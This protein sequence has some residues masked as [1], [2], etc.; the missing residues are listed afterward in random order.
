MGDFADPR[1]R[2]IDRLLE[3]VYEPGVGGVGGM[4]G[5]GLSNQRLLRWLGDLRHYFSADVRRIIVNDA[6]RIHG[7]TRFVEDP[8]LVDEVEADPAFA[9]ALIKLTSTLTVERREAVRQII[10]RVVDQSVDRLRLP[11]EQALRQHL[12]RSRPAHPRR[13]AE[14]DWERTIRANLR[15]YQPER[16]TV[17]PAR[18]IGRPTRQAR[19]TIIICVDSS[20]S[21][22]RSAFHA[23]IIAAII[24]AIP[25]FRTHLVSFD[26]RVADLTDLLTDP[27][28]LLFH[29]SLAGGTDIGKALAYCRTLAAQGSGAII[30]L[31]SDLRDRY[32]ESRLL[33]TAAGIIDDGI[34]LVSI[35]ALDDTGQPQY[36]PVMAGDLASLGVSP[37]AATPDNFPDLLLSVLD[38]EWRV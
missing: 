35:L 7:L 1:D 2:E 13:V 24:A 25:S 11:I 22:E 33:A 38:Q 29:L 8:R 9:R 20:E 34:R 32:P 5:V 4:A 17:I 16:R 18:F 21:M 10:R 30:F 15:H 26:S 14:I 23:A 3:A 31:I 36:D 28:E 37:I 19:R 12:D 27:V 6:I